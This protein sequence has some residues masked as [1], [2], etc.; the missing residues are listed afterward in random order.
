MTDLER[1]RLAVVR[2]LCGDTEGNVR[3]TPPPRDTHLTDR[4]SRLESRLDRLVGDV[5]H[6]RSQLGLHIDQVGH[7]GDSD[8]GREADQPVAC[9]VEAHV[10]VDPGDP[11]RV[12]DD[13][14][15]RRVPVPPLLLDRQHS[16]AFDVLLG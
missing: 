6:V 5:A 3:P 10:A 8:V 13:E 2:A 16:P 14:D 7:D 9:D 12:A 15:V 11:S 4:M 1:R